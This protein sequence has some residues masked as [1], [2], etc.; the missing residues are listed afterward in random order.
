MIF[1]LNYLGKMVEKV[2]AELISAHCEAHNKFHPGQDRTVGGGCSG[3]GNS[4]HSGCME[5]GR[6]G[7]STADG[8]SGRFS[9]RGKRMLDPKNEEDAGGRELSIVG[10]QFY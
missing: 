10:K 4:S 7:S 2:A 1:L 6:G 3:G 8:C 9:K 5:A